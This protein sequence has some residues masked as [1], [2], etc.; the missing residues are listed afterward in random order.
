VPAVKR[1]ERLGDK[2]LISRLGGPN[3]LVDVPGMM[4]KDWE[5]VYWAHLAF[6]TTVRCIVAD[7]ESREAARKGLD[8]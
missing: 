5:R 8:S 6:T 1:A 2:V 7:V 3:R 4:A